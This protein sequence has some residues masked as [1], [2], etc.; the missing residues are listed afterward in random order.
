MRIALR[1]TECFLYLQCFKPLVDR[2]GFSNLKLKP[3]EFVGVRELDFFEDSDLRFY[4]VS[5]VSLT[6]CYTCVFLHVAI[7]ITCK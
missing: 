3:V 4:K 2:P 1:M 7:T 5:K 6:K